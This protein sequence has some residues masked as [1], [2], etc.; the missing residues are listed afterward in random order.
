MKSD[1]YGGIPEK[2]TG[3]CIKTQQEKTIKAYKD[4]QN[5]IANNPCKY[6]LGWAK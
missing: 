2:G 4:W 6:V 3:D 5:Y 1:N